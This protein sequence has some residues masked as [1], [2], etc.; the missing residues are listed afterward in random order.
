MG[1][2]IPHSH[3]KASVGGGVPRGMLRGAG[4]PVT[5][6]VRQTLEAPIPRRM[7]GFGFLWTGGRS[8]E[9]VEAA[10]DSRAQRLALARTLQGVKTAEDEE[11]DEVEFELTSTDQ[12]GEFRTG[13]AI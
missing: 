11:G 12:R 13:P 8:I 9:A 1:G 5:Y 10:G 6:E 7:S 3:S 4:L 2:A